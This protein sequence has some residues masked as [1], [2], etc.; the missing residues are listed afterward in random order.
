MQKEAVARQPWA[1]A[2]AVS[3]DLPPV[4]AKQGWIALPQTVSLA[5]L[6]AYTL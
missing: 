5:R 1:C 2:T 3:E 4:A 6:A